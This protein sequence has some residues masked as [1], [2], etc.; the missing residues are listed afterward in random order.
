MELLYEHPFITTWF[1]GCVG[2]WLTAAAG[3]LNTK[4]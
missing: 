3:Q 2:F 4:K 1:I